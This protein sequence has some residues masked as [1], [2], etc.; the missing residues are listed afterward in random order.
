[1]AVRHCAGCGLPLAERRA[2]ARTCGATC[3]QRLHRQ[4]AVAGA[5]PWRAA[6]R[7]LEREYPERW[8]RP[9]PR[10]VIRTADDDGFVEAGWSCDEREALNDWE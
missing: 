7:R 10:V 6:A 3:R 4:R 5:E 1:M 2:D 8:G 9:A